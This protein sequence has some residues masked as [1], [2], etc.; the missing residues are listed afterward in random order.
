MAKF[1]DADG[2]SF[3]WSQLSLQDYPN[4]ETLMAVINA[5]DN[6]K[7]N[8]NDVDTKDS[9]LQQQINNI[10]K[11]PSVTASDN[12]KFLRVVSGKWSAATIL[13]AEEVGF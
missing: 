11:I 13:N 10:V 3:L 5:I 9:S 6:T 1:L 7:A 8:K 2:V 12:G 4:N